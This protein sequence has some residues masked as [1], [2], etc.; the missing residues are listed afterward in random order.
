M[1]SIELNG[2]TYVIQGGLRESYVRRLSESRRNVGVQ[3]RVDDSSINRYVAPAFPEG[4]GWARMK[5][6]S[7]R[8]VGGLLD[9]TCWT[10]L[11]PITLGKLQ[12]TQTHASDADHFRKAV[13]FKGDLWGMFEEDYSASALGSVV[14]RLFG[15]TS[16]DWTGGGV[17]TSHGST[18]ANG[19][20]GWDMVVHKSSLFAIC[21]TNAG[22]SVDDTFTAHSSTDGITWA[23]AGGTG[24]PDNTTSNEYITSAIA[25]RNN[26]DDDMARLLSFGNVLLVALFRHPDSADGDGTIEVL[27]TTDSG[28]NWAPDVTIPSGDGPKA[29]LDWFN[30]SATRSPVLIT[31]EG[32][33]SIDTSANT[34]ELIYA[35]DG[36]PA[37][38]RWATVGN[39]GA[40]YVSLGSGDILRLT[41]S[42][43]TSGSTLLE[44]L[45]IAPA[46][47]GLVTTR[48]GHVNY[49]LATPTKWLL[50]AYSGHVAN[51]F[52][53]IFMLDTSVLRFDPETGSPYMAL[54]HMWQDA[55]GDL[56]IVS[57]AYS[58]EDDATPRLHWAVEGSAASINYHIEEPFAHPE[59]SSTIKYQDDN[60][61]FLRLPVDD[62]GDPQTTATILQSLVDADDLSATTSGEYIEEQFG[63]DGAA[64]TGTTLGNYLSG[65][66]SL[67]FGSGVGVAGKTIGRRLNFFRSATNTN[68][69][70][71]HESELQASHVLL[72]KK[73]YDFVIDIA[74]SAAL[75]SPTVTANQRAEEVII[76]AIEAVAESTTLV[77]FQSGRMTQAN[78]KIPNDSPPVFD[79]TIEESSDSNLGYRTG[80][81]SVHVEEGI[82]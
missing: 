5:R 12:E 35:L 41:I 76:S 73:A 67:S 82:G 38:G 8:G 62:L 40:L 42:R 14:S 61:S 81:C 46:G 78:V 39:D 71:L 47:D 31:A 68:T 1:P 25:R 74:A 20:R 55:T 49:M 51:T 17:I 21:N 48:T 26:F 24:F 44:V 18:N 22:G 2:V 10:A 15:A 23:D 66:K 72:D 50:I 43:T 69:P 33:W 63:V 59:Q 29:F 58:T 13:P 56:D 30:L 65:T 16:D 19:T 54:H 4:M 52:A 45:N 57:M 11:G 6:D 36:D 60:I 79:F 37:N 34:F 27:N 80:L 77:T 3:K 28:T 32:I 75:L 9:S 53:S 70:K 64:D 7:G